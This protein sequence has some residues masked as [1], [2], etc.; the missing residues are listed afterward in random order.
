M[1]SPPWLPAPVGVAVALAAA[2]AGG[3][4]PDVIARWGTAVVRRGDVDTVVQRLGLAASGDEPQRQRAEAAILEQVVDDR[5]LRGELDRM[6]I[7]PTGAEIQASVARLREQ[8]AT[9][10]LVF[11]NFLA[12]TGRTPGD[13]D[14]QV[15]LEIALEKFIRPQITAEAIAKT[16]EQNRR[17]LDGTRLRVSH[18]VLRPDAGGPADAGA[19]LLDR[20]AAI[21][22]QIVQGRLSFAEAARRYSAG[23]SRRLGGDLGWIGR[24]GPLVDVFASRAYKLA[25]GSVSPPFSSPQGVHVVT[26]T[27]VEPGRVGVD[28][29]RPR[30]EKILAQ[31]LVRGLIAAGRRRLPVTISAGVPYFDPATVDQPLDERRVLVAPGE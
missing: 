20:A 7:R 14:K 17:E 22:Q 4:D 6:G 16:F 3:Q 27:D 15:A 24:D 2:L 21:R 13:L 30:L 26:V 8:V 10:G 25:K 18:I 23:P 11:E 28:A 1:P 29:V 31:E 9:R 19:G 12:A 5:I